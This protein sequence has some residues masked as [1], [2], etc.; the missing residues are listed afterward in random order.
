MSIVPAAWQAPVEAAERE[1]GIVGRLPTA[2]FRATIAHESARFTRL[3]E[4]LNYSADR[5]RAVWPKRFP[6]LESAQDVARQ[7]EKIA[8]KV[9]AGRMG[10]I[11]PGDGWRYRGRG[12]IQLTGR[13]NYRACGV[14]LG[15]D[16]L[17]NPD[18]LLQPE[19]AARS[20]GWFWR[21]NGCQ[22]L[23]E[24]GD[25]EAVT[26]KVNG[27]LNGMADRRQLFETELAGTA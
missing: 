1:F 9:Y 23:A 26:R 21:V 20:A 18:L 25:L 7:P 5:L 16:L 8:N 10:N 4:N 3:S 19:Y 6:T 11:D 22:P 2:M 13:G 17:A 15:V 24:A 12:L 27:G 14:A